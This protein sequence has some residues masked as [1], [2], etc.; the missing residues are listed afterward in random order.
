MSWVWSCSGYGSPRDVYEG[1][2]VR[3][4]WPQGHLRMVWG[5]V[6]TPS[7][8]G[9][10]FLNCKMVSFPSALP[11]LFIPCIKQKGEET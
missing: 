10:G 8:L 6:F 9:L 7:L 4:V 3:A 11:P 5:F 1:L 2:W